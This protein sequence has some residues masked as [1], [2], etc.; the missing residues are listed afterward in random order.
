MAIGFFFSKRDPT[1]N[2]TLTEEMINRVALG[3]IIPIEQKN[4]YPEDF[5]CT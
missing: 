5:C 3:M 1:I 2:S 4:R